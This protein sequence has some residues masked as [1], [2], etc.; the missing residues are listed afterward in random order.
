MGGVDED[1]FL[2]L[3]DGWWM[4]RVA[5]SPDD[6]YEPTDEEEAIEEGFRAFVDRKG[7][8]FEGPADLAMHLEEWVSLH[9][10][11]S[12]PE[13]RKMIEEVLATWRSIAKPRRRR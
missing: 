3:C 6:S 2:H 10:G 13:A 12:H 5:E 7:D 8:R 1:V 11:D 9:G 4:G